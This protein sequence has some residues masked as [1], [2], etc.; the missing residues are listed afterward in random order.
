MSGL[1]RH[2]NAMHPPVVNHVQPLPM[3]LPSLPP[4]DMDFNDGDDNPGLQEP[5]Q[6]NVQTLHH[7]FLNG[8]LFVCTFLF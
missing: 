1:T 4:D 3:R 8:M 2:R 5:I 6:G 7:P